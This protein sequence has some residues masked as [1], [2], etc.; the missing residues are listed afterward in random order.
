[1]R[2]NPENIL[3]LLMALAILALLNGCRS[4]GVR[5]QIID[6]PDAHVELH[7]TRTRASQGKTVDVPTDIGRGASSAVG[8]A[9][10]SAPA[11]NDQ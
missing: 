3:E 5:I 6:S 2:I 11:G 7:D 8:P 10:Q 4:A 1:M 9:A